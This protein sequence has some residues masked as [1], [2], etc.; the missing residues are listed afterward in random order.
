MK[1]AAAIMAAFVY[2][3]AIRD[4]KIPRKPVQILNP[5]ASPAPAPATQ[6]VSTSA[7]R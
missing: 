6:P 7:A 5:N 2:N 4:E 1:Q 3:T